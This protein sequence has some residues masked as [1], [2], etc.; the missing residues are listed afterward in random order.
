MINSNIL[1]ALQHTKAEK[2][3]DGSWRVY[4]RSVNLTRCFTVSGNVLELITESATRVAMDCADSTPGDACKFMSLQIRRSDKSAAETPCKLKGNGPGGFEELLM[5][6]AARLEK[7]KILT[8]GRY[9][10]ASVMLP[11]SKFPMQTPSLPDFEGVWKEGK[12]FIIEAK[13]CS[14]SAFEITKAKLKPKQVRHI[15]TRRKFGV[16]GF[17]LIHFNERQGKTFYE[18]PVTIGIPVKSENEA[19]LSVWEKF[20]ADSKGAYAGSLDRNAV[21]DVGTVMRWHVPGQCKSPR[22]DIQQFLNDCA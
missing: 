15:L 2:Q 12:Q 20:A 5:T 10:V 9:P 22:P 19:G 3:N 21:Y 18:P 16:P 1:K 6:E 14:Q 13:V 7:K 17:L 4:D 8:M 11:N